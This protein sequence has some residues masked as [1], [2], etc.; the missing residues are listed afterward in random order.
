MSESLHI[1]HKLVVEVETNSKETGFAIR[2]NA[3]G[4]ISGRLSP[5]LE[6]LFRE[7]EKKLNGNVLTFDRISID[8]SAGTTDLSRSDI[9]RLICNAI[10]EE[11]K[12]AFPV[13][14]EPVSSPGSEKD[15]ERLIP[16]AKRQ[17]Q[18]VFHFLKTGERPW[19]IPDNASLSKLMETPSLLELARTDVETLVQ[20]LASGN[21]ETFLKR[22]IF[23]LPESVLI[24]WF[25]RAFQIPDE[26]KA[27]APKILAVLQGRKK[28][29]W[30]KLLLEAFREFQR[31]GT[32]SAVSR[33][34][35]LFLL[36]NREAADPPIV[37]LKT[38][39]AFVKAILGE[40]AFPA[41]SEKALEVLLE[42]HSKEQPPDP[43]KSEELLEKAEEVIEDPGVPV[44][45]AGLILLHPFLRPFFTAIGLM[46]ENQITDPELA[47][48]VLH[49]LATGN[50][51]D[52]EYELR[53]E[54]FLCGI[55]GHEPI[56]REITITEEIKEETGKLLGVVLE[57]WK[58]LRSDS[59]DL[60][61]NE[62]LQREAKIITE[63]HQTTRLV[64]ERKTQD[65]LLDSLPWNLGIVKVDWRKDLLFVE[66]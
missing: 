33:E 22:M 46:E 59:V 14:T 4:F 19:W 5:A 7:L 38:A 6:E 50:E 54:K 53:F 20:E 42:Q 26:P 28:E 32:I 61:R 49:F 58:G 56:Q 25:A 1:V 21:S 15:P 60:L 44:E 27:I 31:S 43:E 8:V 51:C 30:W 37:Q 48:H 2:D 62:F 57:H 45:N 63:E 12:A 39:A 47:A 64:F 52:W 13:V 16:V 65:I 10:Q 34:R 66:W 17:L 55:P 36:I 3:A 29:K 40:K 11:V 24:E 41:I 35:L 9:D 23:Q 18:S